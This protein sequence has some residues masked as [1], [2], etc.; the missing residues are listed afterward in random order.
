MPITRPV[1]G[2]PTPFTVAQNLAH[3]R[4]NPANPANPLDKN[5]RTI[6]FEQLRR[7]QLQSEIISLLQSLPVNKLPDILNIEPSDISRLSNT[8]LCDL[9]HTI[10]DHQMKAAKIPPAAQTSNPSR[11]RRARV[12]ITLLVGVISC[13]AAAAIKLSIKE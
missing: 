2:V 8:E 12:A 4:N 5:K 6:E 11:A 13:I 9:Y 10:I 3:Q 7:I 1:G